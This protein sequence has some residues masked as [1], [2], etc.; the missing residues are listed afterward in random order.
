MQHIHKKS[1]PRHK[2]SH[3]NAIKTDK[4]EVFDWEITSVPLQQWEQIIAG[5]LK[6]CKPLWL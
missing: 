3:L 2:N 6:V 1:A 4:F 5:C